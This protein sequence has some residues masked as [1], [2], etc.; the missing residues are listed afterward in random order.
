MTQLLQGETIKASLE[1]AVYIN[2]Q[3]I[4]YLMDRSRL[5]DL[6]IKI[7]SAEP[8]ASTDDLP[9]PYNGDYGDGYLVGD[10]MPYRLYIWTRDNNEYN[11]KWFDWGE[12]NA[13]SIV[14]GPAGPQGVQGPQGDP[15]S[16]WYTQGG[17]PVSGP[18]IKEND[19]AL[20]TSNGDVYQYVNGVWE[21]TGNIRGAQGIQGIQGIRG[22][23]GI[24][25]I[26]GE[27]GPQGPQGEPFRILATLANTSQLPTPS[28][29]PVNSAYL[30]PDESGAEHIWVITG[31]SAADYV[32][33]DAGSF[34]GGTKINIDG[35]SQGSVEMKNVFN[36]AATYQIGDN[37]QVSSNGSEL[38]FSNLQVTGT[39][40]T[41]GTIDTT[42]TIELPITTDDTLEVNSVNNV[43]TFSVSEAYKAQLEAE[44]AAAS[45]EAVVINAPT[46]STQGTLEDEQ[47]VTL[48]S[49]H[50][51]YILLNGEYYYLQDM[52]DTQGF[53]VYTHVGSVGT[54]Q[55]VKTI[56]IT[57]STKSWVLTT[58]YVLNESD[59]L[60]VYDVCIIIQPFA[61]YR[62][63]GV[64]NNTPP[65]YFGP[66]NNNASGR[67]YAARYRL[68]FIIVTTDNIL[69]PYTFPLPVA[70]YGQNKFA[71]MKAV[72]A[73]TNRTQ[74][75]R[76][77]FIANH[78][79]SYND[80]TGSSFNISSTVGK[81]VVSGIFC[82]GSSEEYWKHFKWGL[83]NNVE[84]KLL[85]KAYAQGNSTYGGLKI[86]YTAADGVEYECYG[87]CALF[88]NPL[89]RVAANPDSP[90]SGE[91]SWSQY[92]Y[93][94]VCIGDVATGV[95]SDARCAPTA[96][97]M[98]NFNQVSVYPLSIQSIIGD[99]T[100]DTL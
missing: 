100:P 66:Y 26:Q 1:E 64:A 20:N 36:G 40:L 65:Y 28:S 30:I 68:N 2:K 6:G 32:W 57:M 60:Y 22:P 45:G 48:T 63:Q 86:L 96:S 29:V 98:F 52:N 11:G 15:G 76:A 78:L 77:I 56:S 18:T 34:G 4:E 73:I 43:A 35:V 61:Y 79:P 17:V 23:Q 7:V 54:R 62:L 85:G 39:N 84:F 31:T 9:L 75:E 94:V 90:T 74:V 71:T 37:T 41:G 70:K 24:Q 58:N 46:T 10:E 14:P 88:Q 89:S 8:Y 12:L 44:I 81:T 49:N 21:Y 16:K 80:S 25:G 13:P 55:F 47:Y 83:E 5:A 67:S 82:S 51:N 93:G 27:V 59:K 69:G 42:A 50:N 19:Q 99:E 91:M 87:I 53:I 3:G 92:P 72:T 97:G 33:H 38:T 95:S